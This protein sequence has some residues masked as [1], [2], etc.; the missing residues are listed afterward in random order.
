MRMTRLR[1]EISLESFLPFVRPAFMLKY[2][3]IPCLTSTRN[4]HVTVSS[5]ESIFKFRI[6]FRKVVTPHLLEEWRQ[7]FG[8]MFRI[9]ALFY[10]DVD[11]V[12][13]VCCALYVLVECCYYS[14]DSLEVA[15]SMISMVSPF[16]NR[17]GLSKSH[18]WL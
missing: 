6:P 10:Y 1:F 14:S 15:A 13:Y 11:L 8:M 9:H 12:D 2:V 7:L 3:S 4:C 17:I 16:Q 18:T 5:F